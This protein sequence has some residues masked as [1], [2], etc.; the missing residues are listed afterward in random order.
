MA[1]PRF[2]SLHPSFQEPVSSV[3]V[4]GIGKGAFGFIS[5]MNCDGLDLAWK[6]QNSRSPQDRKAF[7]D[8]VAIIRRINAAGCSRY[9]VQAYA[10]KDDDPDYSI[11]IMEYVSGG[12]LWGFLSKNKGSIPWDFK[13]GVIAQVC[14]GLQFLHDLR[15]IHRDIKPENIFVQA[16]GVAKIGDYGLSVAL[17]PNGKCPGLTE[18]KVGTPLFMSPEPIY[19]QNPKTATDVWALGIV[20]EV[21][22]TELEAHA[23]RKPRNMSILQGYILGGT[24]QA[25]VP[26]YLAQ[27]FSPDMPAAMRV[28][29][30]AGLKRCFEQEPDLR[31]TAWEFAQ[32]VGGV[33]SVPPIAPV[34]A[35]PA[36][37]VVP[38]APVVA[39]PAPVAALPAPPVA[40]PLPNYV[41][42]RGLLFRSAVMPALN[43]PSAQPIFRS[44][45]GIY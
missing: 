37:V 41:G 38:P 21:I 6:Y 9:V 39:P 23:L 43:T 45:S 22:I 29:I 33:A 36:P 26:R 12:D 27:R 2:T 32:I 35:P 19:D 10:T 34:V 14:L 24:S 16:N 18:R 8:E 30:Q 31:I 15:I 3:K 4:R 28:G 42:A 20:I 5:L 1:A 17:D 44:R 13:R 40:A 11:L 7:N 25:D